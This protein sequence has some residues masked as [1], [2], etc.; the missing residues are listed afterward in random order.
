MLMIGGGSSERLT[1]TCQATPRRMRGAPPQKLAPGNSTAWAC[2]R[3]DVSVLALQQG[4]DDANELASDGDEGFL[5]GLALVH[6]GSIVGSQVRVVLDADQSR[7]VE[8][9]AQLRHSPFGQVHVSGGELTRLIAT[10]GEATLGY[11]GIG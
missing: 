4:V 7:S 6:F 5:L 3:S 11:Q 1:I 10:W 2:L 9:T 8:D